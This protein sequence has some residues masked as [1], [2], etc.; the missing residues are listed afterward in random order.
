MAACSPAL[1]H[2][3]CQHSTASTKSD[4]CFKKNDIFL[5][6]KKALH[7]AKKQIST[8]LNCFLQHFNARSFMIL[9][10]SLA[11]RQQHILL[12]DKVDNTG[13]TFQVSGSLW[14]GLSGVDRK[15]KWET[16]FF[17]GT[18]TTNGL[19]A[20]I[21]QALF[22]CRS[23]RTLG[24]C[25]HMQ[26][27]RHSSKGILETIVSLSLLLNKP[28]VMVTFLRVHRYRRTRIFFKYTSNSWVNSAVFALPQTRKAE[29]KSVRSLSAVESRPLQ[30]SRLW[31][32]SHQPCYIN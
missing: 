15:E 1:Q 26:S 17:P 2:V 6:A 12:V 10:F 21:H 11:E 20:S 9:H 3:H 28:V 24:N 29:I 13:V 25:T 32:E 8:Q 4:I 7:I 23:R 18:Q 5:S 16:E 27:V 30:L 31:A 19:K 14:S 22:R